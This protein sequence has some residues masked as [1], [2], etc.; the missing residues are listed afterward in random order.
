MADDRGKEFRAHQEGWLTKQPTQPWCQSHNPGTRGPIF[1]TA[2]PNSRLHPFT[3]PTAPITIFPDQFVVYIAKIKLFSEPQCK[4]T[5]LSQVT[6]R[7]A[8]R[9]TLV[10]VT[11][12][13]FPE[14]NC[15]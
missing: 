13:L 1:T 12:T 11:I 7:S 5:S 15:T 8:K 9:T 4:N 3:F 14:L 2:V 6:G 10:S